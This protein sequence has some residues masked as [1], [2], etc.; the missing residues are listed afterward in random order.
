MSDTRRLT[1]GGP[2]ATTERPDAVNGQ[3]CSLFE[4]KFTETD[5]RITFSRRYAHLLL[6]RSRNVII[7]VHP[8]LIIARR[9]IVKAKGAVA[10]DACD[11]IGAR[12]RGPIATLP[13]LFPW[14]F[15]T[16]PPARWLVR[17]RPP[18]LPAELV[19]ARVGEPH[20]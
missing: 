19:E 13:R 3:S 7:A 16:I 8:K 4:P 6:Q 15:S 11:E 1:P 18:P 10:G 2:H 12:P 5:R 17:L 9:C 20:D 14:A